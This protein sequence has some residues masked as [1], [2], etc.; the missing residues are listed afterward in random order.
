MSAG[1]KLENV[2]RGGQLLKALRAGLAAQLVVTFLVLLV[3]G[4]YH[5]AHSEFPGHEHPPGTPDHVHSLEMVTGWLVV[6][7]IL[8]TALSE[9]PQVGFAFLLPGSWFPQALRLRVNGSR[10]P[11]AALLIA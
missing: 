8:V 11:P 9:L 5:A 10:S 6:S 3:L 1:V 7:H 2:K 4:P